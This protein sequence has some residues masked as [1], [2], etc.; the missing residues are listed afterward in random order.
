MIE[1]RREMDK[2]K[3]SIASALKLQ[4]KQTKS[5][6]DEIRN[7][8]RVTKLVQRQV[9]LQKEMQGMKQAESSIRLPGMGGK[10]K[11]ILGKLGGLSRFAG[12]TG[13][14]AG[15]AMFAGSRAMKAGRHFEGGIEDR[16]ALRGRGV[17]DLDIQ[18]K[19]SAQ[20]AGLNSQSMRRARLQ[21][22]D[23]FGKQGSTQQAVTQRASVERNF[24]LQQGTMAGLGG[25]MRGNL[26]GEGAQKAMMTIQAGLIS[27]GITDEIGPYLE[28]AA[29]ML[30]SLN[31]NGFTFNDSAMAI[32]N[33]LTASGLSA[34]RGGKMITG[35]DKA[36][37]GSS[38]EANA[39]FQQIFSRAG[40][41]G[42]SIGGLQAGIRMGGLTGGG[43]GPEGSM[44]E[45]DRRTFKGIGLG[46]PSHSQKIAKAFVGQMDDLFGDDASVTKLLNDPNTK[47]KGESQRLHRNKF[48]MK[49]LN[50]SNEGEAAR[51]NKMLTDI[52]DPKTNEKQRKE[53]EGK[54]KSLSEGNSELGNLKT[55]NTS[56]AG[57]WDVL[58]NQH[59]TIKDE[60][61]GKVA[62]AI[63]SIDRTM[64]KLDLALS[65]LLGFFGIETPGEKVAE[66]MSGERALD[67]KTFDQATMGD[68]KKEREFSKNLANEFTKNQERMNELKDKGA[69]KEWEVVNGQLTGTKEAREFADLERKNKKISDTFRKIE[70]ADPTG[71]MKNDKVRK[72]FNAQTEKRSRAEQGESGSIRGILS[73]FISGDDYKST[74]KRKGEGGNEDTREA[75][76]SIDL[77]PLLKE[78]ITVNRGT[79]SSTERIER[80][81]LMSLPPKKEVTGK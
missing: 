69:N 15:G 62:P 11:G 79:K 27:S 72:Q 25:Q 51:V 44:S 16:L 67:Q 34:E 3:N 24:G 70:G 30:T 18:D 56:T 55:I 63:M 64:M 7:R 60:L 65:A 32:L 13:L 21:S 76:R 58:K 78:L 59:S 71:F 22:M 2:N 40:V 45:V 50:L 75:L 38:G 47:Q 9:K 41:G 4:Q 6:A 81:P 10:G 31:E 53:L 33:N 80:K 57:V 42:K 17:G 46:D 26:G 20:A 8:E 1:L 66:A 28:T 35:V 36:I 61:G 43:L 23:I 19:G 77:A 54:I 68:P 49:S 73:K 29:G 74:I 37:K 14:L 12:P 5:V 39:L 48:I 52:A